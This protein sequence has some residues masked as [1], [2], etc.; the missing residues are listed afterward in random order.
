V[1]LGEGQR[2]EI[3]PDLFRVLVAVVCI[4]HLVERDSRLPNSQ[5]TAFDPANDLGQCS[6]RNRHR[7]EILIYNPQHPCGTYEHVH[8][9]SF[10][11]IQLLSDTPWVEDSRARRR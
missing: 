4:D 3:I 5:R 8:R 1:D 2:I 10:V 9:A 6:E 7:I 11:L